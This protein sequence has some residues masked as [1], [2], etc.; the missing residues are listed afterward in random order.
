MTTKGQETS[1]TS[2]VTDETNNGSSM[3]EAVNENDDDEIAP[4]PTL[5]KKKRHS[6]QGSGYSSK[7]PHD[8]DVLLGRGKPVSLLRNLVLGKSSG[9]TFPSFSTCSF[10]LFLSCCIFSWCLKIQSHPGNQHMLGLIHHYSDEYDRIG[11]SDKFRIIEDIM[12]RIEARGGRFMEYE[13]SKKHWEEVPRAA[14]YNKVSHAFRSLRR[15]NLP[16]EKKKQGHDESSSSKKSSDG[17]RS[18]A[19]SGFDATPM[20]GFPPFMNHVMGGFVSPPFPPPMPAMMG[21]AIEVGGVVPG[22]GEV[23]PQ[24][25]YWTKPRDPVGR[26]PGSDPLSSSMTDAP[27]GDDAENVCAV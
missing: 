3:P 4:M 26:V 8:Q 12:G 22:W 14:A 21:A 24:Q 2:V 16:P 1:P 15:A 6:K 13:Q 27:A 20:P 10:C 18:A 7:D 9:F 17:E 11:R 23:D 25:T 5:S 19:A